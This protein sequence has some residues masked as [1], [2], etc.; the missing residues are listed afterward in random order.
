MFDNLSVM[1]A[2]TASLFLDVTQQ[3][4]LV[5]ICNQ[6]TSSVNNNSSKIFDI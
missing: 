1:A 5:F 3:Q 6:E 4:N 2:T